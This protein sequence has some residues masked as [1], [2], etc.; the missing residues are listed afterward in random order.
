MRS[1]YKTASERIEVGSEM[2]TIQL[3]FGWKRR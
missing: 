2:M 1:I 3:G